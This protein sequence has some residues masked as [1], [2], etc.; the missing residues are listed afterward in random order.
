MNYRPLIHE[1]FYPEG[2]DTFEYPL[3]VEHFLHNHES[4]VPGWIHQFA[5]MTPS[6]SKQ[7][8]SE[9]VASIDRAE[10]S[11]FIRIVK[12]LAPYSIVIHDSNSWL[13][14]KT[15]DQFDEPSVHGNM[16]QISAP[17]E[18][19][20]WPLY[21]DSEAM[22]PLKHLLHHFGDTRIDVPPTFGIICPMNMEP[23][24][25]DDKTFAWRNIG[26]WTGAYPVYDEGNGDC[27]LVRSDGVFG[28]W[29]HELCDEPTGAVTE[30]GS[31]SQ[32]I[33]YLA[34]ET[35]IGR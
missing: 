3:P 11:A 26:N 8:F 33:E 28:K 34:N 18:T 5:K 13:L 1:W 31:F 12:S 6:E 14:C 29:C 21:F 23:A 25:E 19:I 20:E 35:G 22:S 24:I 4:E 9:Y 15:E 32:F 27:V 17:A 10:L 16:L 30:I 7:V 2:P